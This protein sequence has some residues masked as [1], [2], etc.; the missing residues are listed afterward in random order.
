MRFNYLFLFGGLSAVSARTLDTRQDAL[1]NR[2]IVSLKAGVDATAVESHL[3]WVRDVHRKR[4]LARRDITG[5][6][7]R[8]NI[9]AFHAYAGSFDEQTIA[10]IKAHDAVEIVE[11][12]SP[13]E[14]FG[15]VT[16]TGATW[17]LGAISHATSINTNASLVDG[18]EY[19]YDENGGNGTFAYVV[20]WGVWAENPDFEGRVELGYTVYP[21]LPFEDTD[22]HGTHVAGTIA[23]KTW[24]VAKK[25]HIVAVK[26]IAPNQG[27]TSQFMEGF[28]WAVNNITATPGRAAVSVINM[29]LGGP[30]DYAFNNLVDAAS[31]E[32]V[33]TVVAAGNAAI[34]VSRISPAGAPTAI[35]V[36]ASDISN[37]AANTSNYGTGIDL[38][39]PG[40]NISSLSLTAGESAV[41]SGTSMASPHVAGLALYLKSVESGLETVDAI[42]ARILALSRAD[43]L[44]EVPANTA[45]LFAYNGV[46]GA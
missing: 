30:T 24:G 35:T 39:A 41:M 29:S 9:G 13:I 33:L 10:E 43:M 26:V 22:G 7:N 40:V 19:L 34:D 44:Q 32:G 4:N 37:T 16:Q 21:D 12:D 25:A 11:P 8:F 18:F 28:S 31:K 42:T 23:S 38:Y 27:V 3:Q 15:V 36:A 20:D 1:A 17:G 45:N 2:Y 5:I 6:D 14:T 46:G